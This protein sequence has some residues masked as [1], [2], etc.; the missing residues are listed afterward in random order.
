LKLTKYYGYFADVQFASASPILRDEKGERVPLGKRDGDE[1]IWMWRGDRFYCNF[2][3]LQKL[4]K[5]I[6]DN[7]FIQIQE[8]ETYDVK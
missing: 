2:K 7:S 3:G 5:A 4:E 8:N 6:A 1:D